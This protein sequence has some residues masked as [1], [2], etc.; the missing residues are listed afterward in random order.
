M[1]VKAE[2]SASIDD[3]S[4]A[5]PS[6]E[7]DTIVRVKTEPFKSRR[8]RGPRHREL[9]DSSMSMVMPSSLSL[10]YF[11][12]L[13]D[14]TGESSAQHKFPLIYQYYSYTA[15]V[16]VSTDNN[17]YT[18]TVSVADNDASIT[19]RLSGASEVEEEDATLYFTMNE[20]TC[21]VNAEE[22]RSFMVGKFQAWEASSDPDDPQTVVGKRVCW[23]A[24]PGYIIKEGIPTTHKLIIQLFHAI[25][26]DWRFD[27]L[28]PIDDGYA[29]VYK[30]KDDP[31]TELQ[32][33]E[34]DGTYIYYKTR[35]LNLNNFDG[36]WLDPD[37]DEFDY[38][39]YFSGAN[40]FDCPE[41]R[42]EFNDFKI[43]TGPEEVPSA[44]LSEEEKSSCLPMQPGY[45]TAQCQGC[46][47]QDLAVTTEQLFSEALNEKSLGYF[48]TTSKYPDTSQP[49][50][51]L[52]SGAEIDEV[53]NLKSF[54][55]GMVGRPQ[56]RV[57]DQGYCGSCYSIGTTHSITSS[58][59]HQHPDEDP[60]FMFS[61]QQA[62]NC[63]PLYSEVEYTDGTSL[64]YDGLY[65]DNGLGCWG[66]DS[67]SIYNWLVA[68]GSRMPTLET[69][70]YIGFQG[71]CDSSVPSIDTGEFS[72]WLKARCL[73]N[74]N[75]LHAC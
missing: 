3:G 58:Y 36:S 47:L 59:L 40:C 72:H 17:I 34:D 30:P 28:I 65:R 33:R 16:T 20:L 25:E 29:A 45:N 12:P 23:A 27:S 41:V 64:I 61:Y 55:P 46:M 71:G 49:Y 48:Q 52:G 26:N 21:D 22:S 4:T 73:C 50:L 70:P 10:D 32:V 15:R 44:Y 11:S 63:L 24:P 13:D 2:S 67:E 62:M 56:L 43:F 69:V 8:R 42:M 1:R 6:V 39:N 14:F 68:T 51:M 7:T 75:I 54:V 31:Y 66:G 57:Q 35:V 19:S 18:Y 37:D 60:T 9:Q 74:D 38:V 5:Q 53:M